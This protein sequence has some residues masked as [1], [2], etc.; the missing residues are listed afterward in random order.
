M[1]NQLEKLRNSDAGAHGMTP[2]G[3]PSRVGHG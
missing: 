3:A 2:R 1:V